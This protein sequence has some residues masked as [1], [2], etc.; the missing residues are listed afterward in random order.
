M[1]TSGDSVGSHII[2]K[3]LCVTISAPLWARTQ[4][5]PPKWSKWLWVTITVWTRFSG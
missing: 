1:S 2:R 4:A 5:A 3:A